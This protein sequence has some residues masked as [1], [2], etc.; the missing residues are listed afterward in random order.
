MNKNNS[1]SIQ[2]GLILTV[3]HYWQSLGQKIT[4]V[5]P[6]NE[7]LDNVPTHAFHFKSKTTTL[8]CKTTKEYHQGVISFFTLM[9]QN[10][11]QKLGS[12]DVIIFHS[13]CKFIQN[14]LKQRKLNNYYNTNFVFMSIPTSLKE[15]FVENVGSFLSSMLNSTIFIEI[16]LYE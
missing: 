13:E 12:A 15:L 3:N 10:K 7:F 9:R 14:F 4:F 11:S 16:Q 6:K 5:K 8:I 2:L 1:H